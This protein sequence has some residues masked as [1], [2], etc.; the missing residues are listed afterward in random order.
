MKRF[1]LIF[2][3]LLLLLSSCSRNAKI[4]KENKFYAENEPEL[5][6][7][8]KD[9]IPR[10]CI[11]VS[12]E[13]NK[14]DIQEILK[15]QGINYIGN[16]QFK[17]NTK[18]D[19]YTVFLVI[20]TPD[21]SRAN[22]QIDTI[23]NL[24]PCF[25]YRKVAMDSANYH[26]EER[27]YD[28]MFDKKISSINHN[29]SIYFSIRGTNFITIPNFTG[30]L[31]SSGQEKKAKI[32]YSE[33]EII[34]LMIGRFD[35]YETNNIIREKNKKIG[36]STYSLPERHFMIGLIVYDKEE[37]DEGKLNQYV[38]SKLLIQKVYLMSDYKLEKKDCIKFFD[39]TKGFDFRNK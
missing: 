8:C 36:K 17:V 25:F 22:K 4:N 38:N 26:F 11:E 28:F 29:D 32:I 39:D 34:P 2:L 5:I 14:E 33:D 19:Y 27:N 1:Y 12:I 31:M 23:I 21:T 30:H 16:F 13:R 35:D 15:L 18:K 24:D 6:Q 10:G 20:L 37:A 9:S 3:L 7:Y